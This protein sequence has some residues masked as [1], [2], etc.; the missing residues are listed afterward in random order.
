MRTMR[1]KSI[2]TLSILFV[3]CQFI[4]GQKNI[5]NKRVGITFSSFGDNE[6]VQFASLDGAASY[7]SKTFYTF[8]VNYIHPLNSWLDIET[9][10]EYAKHTVTV[11]PNLP[12]D[13]DDSPRNVNFSLINIPITVR[14]NFLHFFFVNGGMLLG[15]DADLSSPIEPGVGALLGIG[16]QYEFKNGIGL[17]V[18][19]Y[20]KAHALIPFS[21]ESYPLRMLESGVR[22]GVTYGLK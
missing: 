14:A 16:A 18:N 11:H 1:L 19:P 22:V 9:G 3:G 13:M 12:P 7:S 21:P 17:F 15:F 5:P 2:I 6:L 4:N 8:G 20:S 10:V